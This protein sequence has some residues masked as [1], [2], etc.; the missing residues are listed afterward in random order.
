MLRR[1]ARWFRRLLLAP[2]G[3][4]PVREIT[5]TASVV[6]DLCAMARSSWPT[7]M[8]AYLSSTR[9]VRDGRL[10]IDEIQVQAY[11]ASDESAV[12][13]LWRLP[14]MTG[15]VGTI[16]SHPSHAYRPSD[17]D[18]SLFAHY[19]FV[20]AIIRHP[21]GGFDDIA[22]YDKEG[23]RVPVRVAEAASG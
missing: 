12:A 1:V 20:H 13:H 23:R 2:V 22:W 10:H 11:E 7:E 5:A 19:G 4:E 3:G 17:A 6:R 14:T 9:G 16:H 21:Y 8:L 15:I 18:L